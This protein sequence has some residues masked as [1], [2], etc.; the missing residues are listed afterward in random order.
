MAKRVGEREGGG[1]EW[2]VGRA[3]RDSYLRRGGGGKS[4]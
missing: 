1:E 4:S 2:R 3:P